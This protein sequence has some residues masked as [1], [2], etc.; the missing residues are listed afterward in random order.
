[1]SRRPNPKPVPYTARDGTKTWQVFY[2]ATT[3]GRRRHAAKDG[4]TCTEYNQM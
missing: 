4:H 2:Y 1:M 3:A